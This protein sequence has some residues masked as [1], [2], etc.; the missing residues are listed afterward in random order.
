MDQ[1]LPTPGV[2]PPPDTSNESIA[3]MAN[4]NYL[5]GH[6]TGGA[7]V[8]Q[9]TE[10]GVLVAEYNTPRE[11][12]GS[13][14]IDLSSN[15]TTLF[16]TSEGKRV[17]RFD[18]GTNTPMAD[19]ATGLPGSNAFALRILPPGDG[20]GGVLVADRE[21]IVRLNGAGAVVQTYDT[22]TENSWFA[23]N[24]DPNGTSFWSGSFDTNNFYRF[25]IASG[26]VEVGPIQ[27]GGQLF[28]LCLKGEPT[29]GG[30]GDQ[31]P[32]EEDDDN[33]GLSNS[34]E[35]LFGNL[36]SDSDSDYDGI[37]DGN[38][39]GNGNGVDD[40][41]ED[42]DDDDAD[43]DCPDDDEDDDGEDDEDEDDDEDD[44]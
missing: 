10:A 31:C 22:A 8:H 28:G 30:G 41:D 17:L 40:E 32:P 9:Y 18:L 15:Q 35:T 21:L 36:V 16:Y 13:D 23:L 14:W 1:V 24:L 20:S 39:D 12:V 4:G 27:S 42:D 7:N 26:A 19:F 29:A 44:D 34:A 43:D 38:D 5:V 33:D 6:A 2:T 11:L 25:N 37:L 3:F